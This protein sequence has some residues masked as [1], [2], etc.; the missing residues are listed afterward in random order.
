M[1][2]QQQ[3]YTLLRAAGMSE[4]G[5][6]GVI[7]NWEC[8]SNCEPYRV[9]GDFS[10][11]RSVS[12]AYVEKVENFQITREEFA[13][14]GTSGF[15]LAQWTYPARRANLYD[16]WRNSPLR[17]D[18]V[19][20]QV[21]FALH[22]LWAEYSGLWN[23]LCS[24]YD[25]YEACGRVCR[26]Y[27]RP[28]INNVDARYSAAVRIRGEIDESYEQPEIPD[29]EKNPDT[30]WPPRMICKG[31]YGADVGVLKSV[32]VARGYY[33]YIDGEDYEFFDERTEA[34]VKKYQRDNGLEVDG[35]AGN[36]TWGKLLQR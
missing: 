36:M 19:Q 14:N 24:T 20:L 34:A 2:Y 18:D 12:K 15:G 6:L 8:E 5:A 32:M 27:E 10:P 1:S 31:M 21:S 16:F 28:A 9:Q 3:I 22:E 26:E 35:I 30:F 25:L 29:A 11:Y 4:A 17:I 33:S 13:G 7:G 23:Y